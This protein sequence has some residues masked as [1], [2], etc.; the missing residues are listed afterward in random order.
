M[1]RLYAL[2]G[3][4]LLIVACGTPAPAPAPAPA[5][6]A[7]QPYSN[8]AQLMRGIPFPNSNI[9]F[10]TQSL[11]PETLKDKKPGDG[12]APV[13]ASA[14]YN[15]VY[16]GWQA[17]ENAALALQETANLIMIPGRLCENGRPVPLDREDYKKFAAGL[18]EAGKVAYKA[19]QSK[20]LDAMLEAGGTVTD[21]CA[22]C[23]EVYREKPDNKDRCTPPAAAAK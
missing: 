8:L 6:P 11:D 13:G 22:A 7:A 18:A 1:K 12:A 10:D 23:H 16:G 15:S 21:A 20:N 3:A 9:I 5:A 14:Q 17:V 4:T 19:A 2:I